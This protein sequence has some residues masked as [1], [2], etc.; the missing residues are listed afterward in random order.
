MGS[1]KEDNHTAVHLLRR[2]FRRFPPVFI[3]LLL[4]L[5]LQR[6]NGDLVHLIF[7][8]GLFLRYERRKGLVLRA[9]AST[10]SERTAKGC[11]RMHIQWHRV[12]V[13]LSCSFSWLIWS[14][15]AC[16]CLRAAWPIARVR[17]ASSSF[18]KTDWAY[19]ARSSDSVC[20]RDV[21]QRCAALGGCLPSSW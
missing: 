8:V 18:S 13:H 4:F 16:S 20:N 21:C 1:H 12:R 7:G 15:C 5:L 11:E 14:D 10:M 2:R 3:F 19:L 9:V 17:V 6:L